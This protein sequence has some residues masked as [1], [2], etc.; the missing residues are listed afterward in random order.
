MRVAGCI[1]GTMKAK[2][3]PVHLSTIRRKY[4][5]K[6]YEC[7]LLRRTVRE[8][9]TVRN[10]TVANLSH[11]PADVIE[12]IRLALSGRKLVPVEDAMQVERSLPTGHVAAVLGT[13]KKLGIAE[14]LSTRPCRERDLVLG[15]IAE[16]VLH[17]TSKLGTLRLWGT[18][19]LAA[20]V[21]VEDAARR[22]RMHWAR[23][24]RA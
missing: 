13:M 8:G 7:H 16:R 23:A 14:L 10:E 9:K 2:R 15:M 18:T 17:P 19:T 12:L 6:V 24:P 1:L 21:G 5:D 3:A 4:K 11:L 22:S 20:D